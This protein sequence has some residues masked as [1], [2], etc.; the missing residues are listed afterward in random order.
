MLSPAPINPESMLAPEDASIG[1]HPSSQPAPAATLWF[2]R[3]IRIFSAIVL[4]YALGFILFFPKALTN[5]DE[6]SYVRHAAAFAAGRVAVDTVDP[7]TGEHRSIIPSDYPAGTSA[8]MVPFIWIAGWR[9]A[10]LRDWW[11]Q[12]P[13]RSLLPNGSLNR[14]ARR[15][16][17]L[18]FWATFP[19][20]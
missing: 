1:V 12:S 4:L 3:Q 2:P 17:L 10:F 13:A 6:V 8:L 5:F 16:S 20:W 11:L 18:S 14:E 15:S 9:G 7:Y 19:P